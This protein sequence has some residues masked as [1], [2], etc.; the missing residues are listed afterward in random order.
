VCVKK[1]IKSFV[2]KRLTL[3]FSLHSHF[4][5]KGLVEK[6]AETHLPF[7]LESLHVIWKLFHI[8]DK[9]IEAW[10]T[11]IS[12]MKDFRAL[13]SSDCNHLFTSRRKNER[14][15]RAKLKNLLPST[16]IQSDIELIYIRGSFNSF[17]KLG[18]ENVSGG[19]EA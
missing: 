14:K 18:V 15:H 12:M 13:S 19:V 7:I 1:E 8:N 4:E 9:S 2:R 5:H 10:N 16:L 6:L 11:I 17:A 3:D